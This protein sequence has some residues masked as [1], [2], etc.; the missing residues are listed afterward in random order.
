MKSSLVVTF[1]FLTLSFSLPSCGDEKDK[2]SE[3]RMGVDDTAPMVVL[4]D[5]KDYITGYR[6]V[7]KI[8]SAKLANLPT[9][10]PTK[11]EPPL[12]PHKAVSV[13][14][15]HLGKS[16]PGTTNLTIY[17][18]SMSKQ[19]TGSDTNLRELSALWAYQISFTATPEPKPQN[20]ALLNVLVLLDGSI[21]IPEVSP[22][23]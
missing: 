10:E 7:W 15:E 9:W 2:G 19:G 23:R 8:D 16:F 22:L 17:S 20:R 6:Y 12:S 13:A 21:V 5:L 4:S 11:E 14:M 1:S 3:I 18:V